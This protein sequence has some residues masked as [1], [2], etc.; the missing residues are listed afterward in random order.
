VLE[1]ALK[2]QDLEQADQVFITST[3]RDL[4]PATFIEGLNARNRGSVVDQLVKALEEY[5]AD[6]VKRNAAPL[7]GQLR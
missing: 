7:L 6:Y 2:P 4:L 1:R 3:T 5:R